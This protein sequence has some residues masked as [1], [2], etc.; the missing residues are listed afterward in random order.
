MFL[1]RPILIAVLLFAVVGYAF[2]CPGMSTPDEAMQCCNTMPCAPHSHQ[3]GEDCCKTMP[4]MH[5]PVGQPSSIHTVSPSLMFFAVLPAI[6]AARLSI[7]TPRVIV[8]HT[9]APPGPQAIDI[10]P[11]R[12]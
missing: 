10:S 7:S 9:H 6:D 2:D 1:G 3:R 8:S 12:I 4:S 5:A 11:L